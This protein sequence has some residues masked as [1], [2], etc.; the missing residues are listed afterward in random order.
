MNNRAIIWILLLGGLCAL[1]YFGGRSGEEPKTVRERIE[2]HLSAYDGSHPELEAY[3]KSR[4]NDADSYEHVETKFF[5]PK[6]EG[7]T[8]AVFVTTFRGNNAFGAKVLQSVKARCEIG[9]GKI[10]E[11]M[12]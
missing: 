12:E 8:D 11:V 9:S 1:F 5:I 4:M 6:D 2:A 10:L 3:I 7:A